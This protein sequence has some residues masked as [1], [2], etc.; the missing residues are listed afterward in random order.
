MSQAHLDALAQSLADKI[1]ARR[2]AA[3]AIFMLEMSKPLCGLAE[4]AG[5]ISLPLV[6]ALVG[7]RR[8]RELMDFLSS[9]DNLERLICL[10][11]EGEGR[12]KGAAHG[13]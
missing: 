8:S 12:Q 3:P 11:E 4:A 7:Q 6:G 9:R 1:V 2:M 5:H 13:N 10:I